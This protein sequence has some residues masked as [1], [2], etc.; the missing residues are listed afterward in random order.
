MNFI[1]NTVLTKAKKAFLD[2]KNNSKKGIR[3]FLPDKFRK[4]ISNKEKGV[5]LNAMNL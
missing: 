5:L 4:Y 3:S 2:T 1:Y